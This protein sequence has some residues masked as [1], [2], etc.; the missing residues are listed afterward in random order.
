MD[1]KIL[2]YSKQQIP[3]LSGAHSYVIMP[4]LLAQIDSTDY[5][6]NQTIDDNPPFTNIYHFASEHIVDHQQHLSNTKILITSNVSNFTDS[7]ADSNRSCTEKSKHKRPPKRTSTKKINKLNLTLEPEPELEESS[8][9][10]E[11]N[12]PIS[13]SK[14]I[15]KE[16]DPIQQPV[17]IENINAEN[18]LNAK[19]VNDDEQN[20]SRFEPFIGLNQPSFIEKPTE[21]NQLSNGDEINNCDDSVTYIV[22]C[23]TLS[24]IDLNHMMNC[25]IAL[26]KLKSADSLGLF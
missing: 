1:P 10:L 8:E 6:P 2:N 12:S 25:F 17:L 11:L 15:F 21:T 13:I 4:A 24:E 14:F 7:V 5:G 26:D 19:Q 9:L 22:N 23:P 18:S 16:T 3:I 20:A